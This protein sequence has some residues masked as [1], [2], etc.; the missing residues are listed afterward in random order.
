MKLWCVDVAADGTTEWHE[1]PVERITPKFVWCW[2]KRLSRAE[3]EQTGHAGFYC[4]EALVP[5]DERR[6]TL[7]EQAER[8]G[9]RKIEILAADEAF[10]TASQQC[11]EAQKQVMGVMH[12][13]FSDRSPA[14]EDNV[15]RMSETYGRAIDAREE[16]WDR[17][18]RYTA[19]EIERA[20]NGWRHPGEEP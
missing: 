9:R 1:C 12:L 6:V 4:V 8:W 10:E 15:Q 11:D 20:K 3:L 14:S 7:A 19:S 5:A 18:N 2:G 17:R 13:Y 16:A